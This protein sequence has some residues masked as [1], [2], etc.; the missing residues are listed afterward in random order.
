MAIYRRARS[1]LGLVPVLALLGLLPLQTQAAEPDA[2]ALALLRQD[3]AKHIS[4]LGLDRWQSL[5]YRGQGIKIAVLD[6]GFRGYRDQLAKTLPTKVETRC[7]RDDG[8][9]EAKNSQHGLLCAEV[10]HTLAPQ[11][12]LLLAT[13]EPDSSES[14]L[15]AVRWAKHA[16]ARIISCSIIMPSWSDGNGGGEFH[17]KLSRILQGYNPSDLSFSAR[18]MKRGIA[19]E[20]TGLGHTLFFACAGNTALRH[21]TGLF[22]AGKDGLQEWESGQS[23]NPVKPWGRERVSV[24]LYGAADTQ[25]EITVRDE[26]GQEISR[27][28]PFPG[29]DSSS[30]AARFI[31]LPQSTYYAQVRRLHGQLGKFHL[32]VLGG[33]LGTV[34]SQG[35][36][37]C[38]ADGPE[39]IAVGA[40]TPTGRRLDYSACGLDSQILKPDFVAPV[41]FPITLRSQSFTGTSAAAPQA[42]ALAAV[43]WS[44]HPNW[45]A[46][47]VHTA[48]IKC[49]RDVGSPGPDCETGHGMIALPE[50]P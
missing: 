38:P 28:R 12:D 41:P 16:G 17:Q 43:L 8:N 29:R 25:Y 48:L 36:V 3:Q 1:I 24:E 49:S 6:T 27:S 33:T 19:D 14:F 31:P 45:N 10:L 30:I 23:T 40:M 34:T 20:P 11:A 9:F 42:A 21:W 35:S 47:Q 44:Q 26:R 50:T 37:A 32:V 46:E 4:L 18:G 5:G 39:V 15:E 7:F 22:H 2:A 13:W